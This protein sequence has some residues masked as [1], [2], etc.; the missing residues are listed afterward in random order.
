MIEKGIDMKI[1]IH[2]DDY[3]VSAHASEDLLELLKEEK[4]NSISVIPNMSCYESCMNRLHEEWDKL[5][6]KPLISV[7][8]NL[9]EGHCVSDVDKVPQLV[10]EQGYFKCSWGSLLKGSYQMG[11]R[12]ELVHEIQL[13]LEAQIERVM[14]DLP[15][16]CALRLDSHQHTHMIPVVRDAML[17]AIDEKKYPVTFV[18]DSREPL[19]PFIQQVSLIPSYGIANLIKNVLLNLYATPLE[20]ALQARH[21]QTSLLWGLNMSGHMDIERIK[22]IFPGMRRYFE[23][24]SNKINRE[25]GMSGGADMGDESQGKAPSMEILF[26][27]GVVLPEE[28]NEEYVKKGFVEF[29]LSQGRKIER[30]GVECLAQEVIHE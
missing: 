30:H 12:K 8:M 29:H 14:A 20:H 5:E 9:M 13:E 10:D 16:G 3:G 6:E 15:E 7:H 18:R 2:A 22:K 17:A 4:L 11:N 28:I 23:K 26:H 27:P 21:I 19:I 25:L 1:D 24:Y